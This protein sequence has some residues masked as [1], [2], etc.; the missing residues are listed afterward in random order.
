MERGNDPNS[1]LVL[2]PGRECCVNCLASETWM[3][4]NC[5]VDKSQVF[6]CVVCVCVLGG[7]KV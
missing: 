5:L 6:L 4:F 3:S 2:P 7:F 1:S